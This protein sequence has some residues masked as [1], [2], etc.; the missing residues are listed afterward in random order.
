MEHHCCVGSARN[1]GNLWTSCLS[2]SLTIKFHHI[3]S[4]VLL[5]DSCFKK[6]ENERMYRRFYKTRC[7][8][9]AH[10][11]MMRDLGSVDVKYEVNKCFFIEY[12][13]VCLPITPWSTGN[14]E[15]NSWK[16]SASPSKTWPT[17]NELMPHLCRYTGATQPRLEPR[18]ESMGSNKLKNSS[19]VVEF[20]SKRTSSHTTVP[21]VH[22]V[23]LRIF[24]EIFKKRKCCATSSKVTAGIFYHLSGDKRHKPQRCEISWEIL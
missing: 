10:K 21:P 20:R 13:L 22:S 8:Q 7:R 18:R 5:G 9:A 11:E 16:I 3:S 15:A 2:L 14:M 12:Q 23:T 6:K 4:H 17:L 24:S 19:G 1:R